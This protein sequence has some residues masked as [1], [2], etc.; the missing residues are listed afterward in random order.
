M[1]RPITHRCPLCAWVGESDDDTCPECG[2][3]LVGYE[4]LEA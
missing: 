4:V 1:M 2:Y 3:G